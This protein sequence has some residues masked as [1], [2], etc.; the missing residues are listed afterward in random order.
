MGSVGHQQDARDDL[1]AIANTPATRHE[2]AR[3]RATLPVARPHPDRG[4]LAL[5]GPQPL[6]AG[7]GP[8]HKSQVT[9]QGIARAM[10]MTIATSDTTVPM[11]N[12]M[13]T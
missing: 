4:S 5:A 9:D 13:I 12:S 10:R 11:A 2:G 6:G 1:T 7:N 3:S 8:A